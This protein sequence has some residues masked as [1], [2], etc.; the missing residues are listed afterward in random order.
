ML[1]VSVGAKVCNWTSVIYYLM[2][3][4][5]KRKKRT[6]TFSPISFS[7]IPVSSVA[8]FEKQ[9]SSKLRDD[10]IATSLLRRFSW[11]NYLVYS[12]RRAVF[13]S[14]LSKKGSSLSKIHGAI[15]ELRKKSFC[16]IIS[17]QFKISTMTWNKCFKQRPGHSR[18]FLEL[19][20]RSRF[21]RLDAF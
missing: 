2:K 15:D 14:G 13:A 20:T 21:S 6:T 4:V 10:S 3:V 17:S 16:F 7:F 18:L 1:K 5:F 12:T 11:N 19:R 8:Q 9:K